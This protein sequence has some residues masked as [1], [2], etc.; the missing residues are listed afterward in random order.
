MARP[1]RLEYPGALHHVHNRGN[2]FGVVFFCDSDRE[3]FLTLLEE[4]ARRFQWIVIQ[5]CLMTNH[6]HLLIETPV[7][8]TLSGGM[9]WL[10]QTYVQRINKKYGRVGSLFQGRYKNHLVEDGTYLLEVLRYI[11]NNPVEA[12]IVERAEDWKWGSHRAVVGLDR[13]PQWM[14]ADRALQPFGQDR[15]QQIDEYR[16]FVD[17]GAGITRAPWE[18]AVAQLFVGSADWVASKRDLIESKPRSTEHPIAQRYAGRPRPTRVVDVVAE[19][20]G[21]DPDQIRN[22]HGTVQREVVA[23]LGCYES[24]ARLSAIA[25]ALRLR[26]TSRVSTLIRKCDGALEKDVALQTVV[27]RCRE[28]LKR[29]EKLLPATLRE[30]YPSVGTARF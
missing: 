15:Q 10:T 27:D 2:N 6:F 3:L 13:M 8:P 14:S 28:L 26:S 18:D 11:A 30:S 22:G 29:E 12:K 7:T 19:V 16:R 23:W 5:F 1:M 20:F 25:A 24:I 21:M 4:A 9:K 17:A